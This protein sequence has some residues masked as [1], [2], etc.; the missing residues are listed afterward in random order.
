MVL[1]ASLILLLFIAVFYK[2]GALKVVKEFKTIEKQDVNIPDDTKLDLGEHVLDES[3]D[4][5]LLDN[6]IPDLKVQADSE[7]VE[8]AES[9]NYGYRPLYVYRK[10]EHSKRRINMYNAFAG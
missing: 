4:E 6:K 7:I 8:T 9:D 10:I 1:K 5:I 3:S 2:I